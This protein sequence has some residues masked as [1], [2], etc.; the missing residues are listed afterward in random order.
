[1]RGTANEGAVFAALSAKPFVVAVYECG[2]LAKTGADWL[3]CSPDGVALIDTRELGF[4][5]GE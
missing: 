5:D 2:M 4:E 1:M 3:A